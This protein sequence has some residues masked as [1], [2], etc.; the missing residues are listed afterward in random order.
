[1][2]RLG[3]LVFRCGAWGHEG[4][5]HKKCFGK[6]LNRAGVNSA[7]AYASFIQVKGVGGNACQVI[8]AVGNMNYLGFAFSGRLGHILQKGS[9]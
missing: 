7:V 5:G 9:A 3:L 1:M 6:L 4:V 8:G 2:L